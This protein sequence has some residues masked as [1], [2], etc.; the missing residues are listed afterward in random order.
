MPIHPND[1]HIFLRC[2]VCSGSFKR[3]IAGAFLPRHE[4]HL[5]MQFHPDALEA[6]NQQD[7]IDEGEHQ[8]DG[9]FCELRIPGIDKPVQACRECRDKVRKIRDESVNRFVTEGIE[10]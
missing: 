10:P 4:E 9:R 8:S 7:A 2:Q 6:W 3:P 1:S 5:L